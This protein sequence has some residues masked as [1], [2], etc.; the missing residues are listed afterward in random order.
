MPPREEWE[1]DEFTAAF[2]EMRHVSDRVAAISSAAYLDN[3]IGLALLTRLIPLGKRW[4]D[5]IFD[6]AVA[7]LN[8]LSSKAKI[9][10]AIGLYGP[11][12]YKDID[13][14]RKIRND[15][16]HTIGPLS[17]SDMVNH[18]EALKTFNLKARSISVLKI[19]FEGEERS[20]PK[21]R[22]IVTTQYLSLQLTMRRTSPDSKWIDELS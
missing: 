2:A 15:F 17:F 8:T 3:A 11:V 13:I 1:G 4:Q 9:G 14:I 21:A 6:G 19:G 16:A 22:Y 7:P 10:Y 5:Q 18:C 20:G 12:T